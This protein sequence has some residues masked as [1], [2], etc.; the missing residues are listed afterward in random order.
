MR[1]RE[2]RENILDPRNDTIGIGAVVDDGA[3]IY[4]TED[5]LDRLVVLDPEPAREQA[6]ARIQEIRRARSLPPLVWDDK[7]DVLARDLARAR[8]KGSEYPPIPSSLGEVNVLFV[9]SPKFEDLEE[10]AD[11]IGSPSYREA[12]LGVAFGRPVQ[13]RGGAYFISLVLLASVRHLELSDRERGELVRAA[14]NKVRLRVGL[15]ELIWRDSLAANA[16]VPKRVGPFQSLT[17]SPKAVETRRRE[18]AYSYETIDLELL[19]AEL[20]TRMLNPG[21]RGFGVSTAFEKNREFP[22]GVFLVTVVVE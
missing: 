7:A 1:S 5:F 21:L 10:R 6:E 16:G 19:P 12:G 17:R 13:A 8:A 2:H 15:V 9:T 18:M 14:V 11:V 4:V 3:V 20:E 22:R